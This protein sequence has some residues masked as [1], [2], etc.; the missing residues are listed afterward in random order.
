M[1]LIAP[2]SRPFLSLA[3]AFAAW[4]AF[5]LAIAL[6]AAAAPDYDT[7]TS[8]FFAAVYGP[9]APVPA[10]AAR[11]TRWDALYFVASAHRGYVYEQEWA[12]AAGLPTLVRAVGRLLGVGAGIWEPGVAIALAHVSHLVAVLAL[13]QLTVVVCADRRLAF[14]SAAVHIL[15]PAGLFLSAPYAE[16]PF[17]CL[18]F[19]GNLLFALGF[20][21]GPDT[22][23]RNAAVVGAGIVFGLATTF[24]SNGLFG[25]LLF[26]VEAV[27][28][29]LAFANGP[30][31]SKMLRLVAPVVGGLFV[32]A[33]AVVPQAVAWMR[34]CGGNSPEADLRPWCSRLI[35]SIYTFVQ[36]EYW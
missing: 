7:S 26:A 36:E 16:S 10:L 9:A 20:K 33:G 25:G 4:K 31:F 23:R 32:A 21:A 19:V 34:Y 1:S 11:L 15:S 14:V 13:Y 18:S 24:R 30:S 3:A 27:Q 5:L 28:G 22:L 35:P 6:G 17:S 12:F 2:D 29:L 8:V